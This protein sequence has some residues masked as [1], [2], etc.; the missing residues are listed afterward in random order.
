MAYTVYDRKAKRTVLPAVTIS[1]AGRII[2]NVAAAQLLHKKKAKAVLL[3]SDSTRRKLAVRPV[4]D[5]D[6]RAYIIA[7]GRNFTQAALVVRAF[8]VALGWDGRKYSLD[9]NW[10]DDSSLLEFEMP[11]WGKLNQEHD[12]ESGT[13][14][15]KAG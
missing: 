5:R 10:D 2:L 12:L 13:T 7:Y 9:A 8:L 1:S 14:E 15:H 6:K 3:L 4:S 11:E